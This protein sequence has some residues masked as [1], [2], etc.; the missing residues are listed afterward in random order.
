MTRPIRISTLVLAILAILA[1]AAPAT[2]GGWAVTSLDP[3]DV[4]VAGQ[5]TTIGFTIRQHGVTPVDL[6]DVGIRITEP[7]KAD[8]YFPAVSDGPGRIGH[9]TASVVFPSEG[10]FS[11][12]VEQG[13]FGPQDLGRVSVTPGADR[14]AGAGAGWQDS[15]ALRYGLP[16][17][18]A[19]CLAFV[20][21]Q[22]VRGRGRLIA[23]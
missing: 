21:G 3:F 1:Y 17:L 13:I 16:L 15:A 5:P 7:G 19:I 9:Y 8:S 23:R 12:L 14:S 2:A 20:V 10:T 22:I 11:W 6:D 4:P 18:A